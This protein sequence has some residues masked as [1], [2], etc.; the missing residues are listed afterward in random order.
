VRWK[1]SIKTDIASRP[2]HHQDTRGR[3]G[4]LGLKLADWQ[5]RNDDD[6]NIYSP[7]VGFTPVAQLSGNLNFSESTI[8]HRPADLQDFI[9]SSF[10]HDA[11]TEIIHPL[12]S[13]PEV[14]FED[15]P[16]D[17]GKE[18]QIDWRLRSIGWV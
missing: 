4:R 7:G 17:Q 13:S 8:Q 2:S 16:F 14:D 11:M 3:G 18:N 10:P 5:S 6:D 1:G 12:P 9:T 15:M